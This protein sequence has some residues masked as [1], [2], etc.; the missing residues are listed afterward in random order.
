M[1]D[2][3]TIGFEDSHP[4]PTLYSLLSTR[5]CN[6]KRFYRFV[7]ENA[8][9]HAP[10]HYTLDNDGTRI[11]DIASGWRTY[12]TDC[13]VHWGDSFYFEIRLEVVGSFF[14][15]GMAPLPN[16]NYQSCTFDMRFYSC[17]I[18]HQE[19]KNR[20]VNGMRLGILYDTPKNEAIMFLNGEKCKKLCD[21]S[22]WTDKTEPCTVYVSLA[23]GGTVI[24]INNEAIKPRH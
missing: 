21:L 17:D 15:L 6:K 20:L 11:T 2:T 3:V 7:P 8:S 5:L 23:L 9:I 10:E 14:V 19:E 13:V 18:E 12:R 16:I 24:Q 1:K 22:A 4:L